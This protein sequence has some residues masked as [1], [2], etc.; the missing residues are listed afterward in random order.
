MP[1]PNLG[2]R[3]IHCLLLSSTLLLLG[4]GW[5]SA[6][7]KVCVSDRQ[8]VFSK[9]VHMIASMRSQ[10]GLTVY[11]PAQPS[12]QLSA[13]LSILGSFEGLSGIANSKAFVRLGH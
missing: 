4:N 2:S 5:M 3:Y 8:V 12:T 9:S 11:T 10:P 13:P 1:L 6:Q 7:E